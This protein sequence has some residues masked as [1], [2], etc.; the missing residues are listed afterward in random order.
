MAKEARKV[1]KE[2]SKKIPPITPAT[3]N[4]R[5]AMQLLQD[6]QAV[7]LHGTAGT[8]KTFIAVHHALTKLFSREV[9]KIIFTRPLSTV[10]NEKMGFLPGDVGE[11]TRPFTEQ[12]TE[13]LSEFA[14]MLM[15]QDAKK[16]EDS[17]EFI[18]LG[19]LRGRNLRNAV[20]I[21]DEMQNSTLIQM[22]TLLT[23]IAEDAQLVI[24]GDTKQADVPMHGRDGLSDLL[25]RT[26]GSTD[27]FIG[28]IKFGIEDIQ[29]SEFVKHVMTIYGDL[30]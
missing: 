20:V 27:S 8:G 11:K 18:P 24:L 19:F 13:Y 7:I 14:P 26:Q 25:Y 15:F 16:I 1:R 23:R 12:F 22:K 17:F 21:A 28:Q 5:I 6:F 3:D 9:S 4:Q 2:P 29:R 10:G 30:A